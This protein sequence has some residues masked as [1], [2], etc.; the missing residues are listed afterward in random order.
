MAQKHRIRTEIGKDQRLTVELKQDYDLL[1]I[2]SLKF[3]QQDIY[4]SLC[5][6]YGVVVGRIS[7]NDGV[8][9]ANSR[10]SIF[11]P[12]TDEDAED[13]V[14]SALY[15]YTT[16]DVRND[17]GY[18]YNL[19]P[20]R[21]QHTGHTPTGTF[22]DQE[23]ILGREEVLEVY[24]KYFKYTTKTNDSGDFMIW[25]VPVGLQTLHVEVDL[26]DMGCNSL[27]PYDL[28]Y[29][30]VSKEK[31]ENNYT[32]MSSDNIDGLPQ[33]VTFDKSIE[34]YPFWG[35]QD[36]CEIGITRS[37]FD[38]G[39]KGIRIEP[40][41]IM[42]GGTFTD[43]GKDALRVNCNVDNQMGEKCRLT[44]FPG[45][46]ESIRFTGQYEK[47]ADGTPNKG[48][49]I[50]E[51]FAIDSQIDEHGRFFFRVPM[52]IRRLITNEFG[53]L[54]ETMDPRKGIATE[55]TYRF[56]LSLNEDTGERNRFTAKFLIPNIREVH[57]ND[58]LNLGR[59]STIDK[60][61]YAFST[62]LDDYPADMIPYMT[63]T[64]QQSIN[65][66]KRGVPQDYFYKFR[67]NR[68]Y[69]VSQYL[70]KYYKKSALESTFAF[71]TKDRRESF[72]GIKE[73]WPAEKDDCSQTNNFFPINEAVRNHRFNF[74][75]IGFLILLEQV[76][77]A[78]ILFIKEFVL[79][80][81]FDFARVIQRLPLKKI[82]RAGNDLM[83]FTKKLQY[84]WISRFSLVTYPDCEKCSEDNEE[85][86]TEFTVEEI[87][88]NDVISGATGTTIFSN[89][90][91][92][93]EYQ[94]SFGSGCNEYEI[95]E[96][97]NSSG[98]TIS[99][100]SCGGGT[101]TY[102][103]AAGEVITVYATSS[104]SATSGSISVNNLGSASGSNLDLDLYFTQSQK[105][106]ITGASWSN[107]EIDIHRYVLEIEVVPSSVGESD[108]QGLNLSG[109][110]DHYY[111]FE[112][113]RGTPFPIDSEGDNSIN[114]LY[115]EIGQVIA[116]IYNEDF[117]ETN[118]G[119]CHTSQGQINFK[120]LIYI[121]SPEVDTSTPPIEEGCSKYDTIY[122]P[123]GSMNLVGITLPTGDGIPLTGGTTTYSNITGPFGG[124]NLTSADINA[125]GF[126]GSTYAGIRDFLIS[127]NY[128][129]ETTSSSVSTLDNP[130]HN[131]V[132]GESN[133]NRNGY[134]LYNQ[135]DSDYD[136]SFGDD[137]DPCGPR[138]QDNYAAVVSLHTRDGGSWWWQNKSYRCVIGAPYKAR[139]NR[140]RKRTE[141]G[142]YMD[143]DKK[144][145]L[146]GY[147]E[148]RDG[149]YTI[150]PLAGKN[151][152]LMADYIR[153]KRLGMVMCGGIT[154][155]IF[156]DSWLSGALYFFQFM[157]R[158]GAD[159]KRYCTD[160]LV[161]VKDD[162][163]THFYYRSTPW[164]ESYNS[165]STDYDKGFYG[166][167][168]KPLEPSPRREINYPTTI[169]DLGPKT[170]W[171]NEVCV[172]PELDPNCSVVRSIGSTSY[173]PV[174]D[175]M[176]YVL[177]SKEIKEKGRLDAPDL[178]DVRG[179]GRMDGDIVQLLN[180]NT[181]TGIYP[182]EIEEVDSPYLD[183]IDAF[184]GQGPVGI[185]FEYSEDD[186]DTETV[187][188]NG[189]RIRICLNKP[190][191]LGD[192]SQYIPYYRWNTWG[193]GF[194][195]KTNKTQGGSGEAQDWVD[196][197]IYTQRI[198]EIRANLNT[199]Q[200]TDPTDDNFYEPYALPPIRDCLEINGVRD[201][202]NDNYKEY[203]GNH[204]ME[205]MGPFHYSFGLRK[206]NTAWDKFIENFGPK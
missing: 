99:Y 127:K 110:N 57:E 64:D 172:D 25:G 42:M 6:D 28:I 49:P 103:L 31:F 39:D 113:G 38:L 144:G 167:N 116:A 143:P 63:G 194:G 98:T 196:T 30:G 87:D 183:Y 197:T 81:L 33:I 29:E 171:I 123:D 122:D 130:W 176:E 107:G 128:L 104:P 74:F 3:T 178:F 117:D 16:T 168:R 13:P 34:V 73:I 66:G 86:A 201:Q 109:N 149:V 89:E 44:T 70:N 162:N 125:L 56:R 181:Q 48:R 26:S 22:P 80:V 47:N 132:P 152:K 129:K 37:D 92:I 159:S 137:E 182:F 91:L 23:D 179:N 163:G 88:I 54:V 199:D 65:D 36:L 198:Q 101:N 112:I 202:A 100:S 155:Y 55:G 140:R 93:E 118:S 153:R 141:T 12:L 2:L 15:P 59:E 180:F 8:G 174:D 192:N 24:E 195:D 10:V 18:R 184:D 5:A 191:F 58:S 94:T 46:I 21:K 1:E 139:A 133:I 119:S 121:D 79:S 52:N 131:G 43:S 161:H 154:S 14:I 108:P 148:F 106:T 164:S 96:T 120:R 32:Y 75:I 40:Y 11:I 105:S 170:S 145:T 138:P 204:H 134:V 151:H 95:T 50:L 146:S 72:I 190:G 124:T 205:L 53:E 9:V 69:T 189:Y 90:Y 7:V 41:A 68:V 67:Y 19:L 188:Y 111:Y 20:S 147:S 83:V 62:N 97:T 175:L 186:P 77:N 157:K 158:G 156:S 203:N 71:F 200:N 177:Q 76:L 35:N 206:G 136:I 78:I 169:I 82:K 150:V 165:S 135:L 173:K 160:N 126:D 187:E 45:D 4:T 84:R 60:K 27:M 85:A 102:T 193:H 17:D 166:Q 115:A 142:A 51:A 185:A 114:G 61:S